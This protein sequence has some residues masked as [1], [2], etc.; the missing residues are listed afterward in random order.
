METK[1][2]LSDIAVNSI[3]EEADEVITT[4]TSDNK[5]SNNSTKIFNLKKTM[6]NIISLHDQKLVQYEQKLVELRYF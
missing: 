5:N 3:I 4:T 2:K 6:R 1:D